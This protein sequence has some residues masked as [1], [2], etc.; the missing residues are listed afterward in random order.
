MPIVQIILLAFVSLAVCSAAGTYLLHLYR[1]GPQLG[2]SSHSR[3]D[4]DSFRTDADIA[5]EALARTPCVV[6]CFPVGDEP[7]QRDDGRWSCS[8][9]IGVPTDDSDDIMMI[10]HG[11]LSRLQ[12]GNISER[13]L[14][15]QLLA[16]RSALRVGADAKTR[17]RE[18][19]G[20]ITAYQMITHRL[21]GEESLPARV[22][23]AIAT[24]RDVERAM[25]IDDDE[26]TTWNESPDHISH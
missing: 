9:C 1:L 11:V 2:S 22:R 21:E 24:A 7:M 25:G 20:I 26:P 13:E 6:C 15:D 23:L 14:E 10:A 19:V 4:S 12:S 5:Y 16:V 18:L 3:G 17:E 8:A